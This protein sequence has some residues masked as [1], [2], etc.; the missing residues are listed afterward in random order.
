MAEC[1]KSYWKKSDYW[2]R[3]VRDVPSKALP[4]PDLPPDDMAVAVAMKEAGFSDVA[5]AYVF[6]YREYI[7]NWA[8]MNAGL[9]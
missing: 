1:T 2:R 9:I 4:L 5:I 6:N 8:H 7:E 3:K